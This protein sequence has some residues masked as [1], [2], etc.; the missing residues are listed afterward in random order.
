MEEWKEAQQERFCLVCGHSLG[1]MGRICDRCGSIRRPAK[2]IGLENP[3]EH[4]SSC[5]RCGEKI[6]QGRKHCPPCAA[7]L[8]AKAHAKDNIKRERQKRPSL[9]ARIIN[10]VKRLLGSGKSNDGGT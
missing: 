1:P 4:F 3:P 7:H 8:K 5:E 9:L 2:V 10:A 6:P